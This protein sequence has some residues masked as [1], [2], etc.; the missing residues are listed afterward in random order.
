MTNK[1]EQIKFLQA[2]IKALADSRDGYKAR[3]DD[4]WR[5]TI[6]YQNELQEKRFEE[7][8][9][10]RSNSCIYLYN[11]M[12]ACRKKKLFAMKE[13]KDCLLALQYRQAEEGGQVE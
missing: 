8:D 5:I 3:Y 2:T 9:C 4:L 12:V 1:D 13:V 7:C 10:D 11:E 6:K